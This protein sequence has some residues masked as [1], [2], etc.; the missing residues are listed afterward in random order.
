MAHTYMVFEF[1]NEEKAQ[2]ARHKLEG[3]KQA[4]RLDKKLQVKFD[5]GDETAPEAAE[6][7]A[8]HE[9]KKDAKA[10]SAAKGAKAGKSKK[11]EKS[12]EE[13][14][15]SGPVKL[16]VRLYFSGHEKITE[17]QWLDRIPA[18]ELFKVAHPHVVHEKDATFDDTNKQF[19]TLE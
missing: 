18:D 10:K 8:E 9:E 12:A 6:P 2:Q 7:E 17:K 13:T 15:D 3:W 16:L 1:P 19:D 14:A 5:R 11:S 4:F